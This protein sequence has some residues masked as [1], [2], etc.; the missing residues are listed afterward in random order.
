[1]A[2]VKTN[3]Q[4]FPI[5]ASLTHTPLFRSVERTITN[6]EAKMN[7]N[8][9]GIL[10]IMTDGGDGSD[11]QWEHLGER[12]QRLMDSGKWTFIYVALGDAEIR[13]ANTMQIPVGNRIILDANAEE[14]M[15][16]ISHAVTI[17]R[18]AP[19]HSKNVFPTA[20]QL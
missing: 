10:V 11:L 2:K 20:K 18:T 6:M 8:D 7:P 5:H 4:K 12:M 17:A 3:S 14:A 15:R 19:E 9:R 1:M 13:A 16:T